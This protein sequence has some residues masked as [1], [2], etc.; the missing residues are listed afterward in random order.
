[1]KQRNRRL[2]AILCVLCMLFTSMPVSAWTDTVPATPTDLL[3]AV[4]EDSENGSEPEQ[5]DTE[6]TETDNREEQETEEPGTEEPKTEEPE[7]KEPETEEP[8]TEEAA[9]EEPGNKE[10]E[11]G[12][13]ETAEPKKEEPVTEEPETEEPATEEPETEEPTTDEPETEEPEI[14]KPAADT[15]ITGSDDITVTGSLEGNPPEDYLIRFIPEKT[16]KLCLILTT[17]VELSA[18]VTDEN[19]GIKKKFAFDHNDEDGMTVLTLPYYKVNRDSTY[20]IRISGRKPADFSIRM[21]KMS[22]LKAEEENDGTDS[23]I[24]AEDSAAS[25]PAETLTDTSSEPQTEIPDET[26]AEPAAENQAAEEGEA[27]AEPTTG[28]S[29]TE[30]TETLA[31]GAD[32]TPTEPAAEDS[33]TE[34]AETQAAGADDTSVT[35][36]AAEIP[37]EPAENPD[38]NRTEKRTESTAGERTETPE[39]DNTP[40]EANEPAQEQPPV[41]D[42]EPAEQDTQDIPLTPADPEPADEETPATRTDL[43]PADPETPANRTDPEPA[44]EETPA[45]QT[46]LGPADEGT[47]ATQTD[48]GPADGETAEVRIDATGSDTEAWITFM[49]DADIPQDAVLQVREIPEE[50]QKKYLARTVRTLKCDDESYLYYTKYLELK[51]LLDGEAVSLDTPVTVH[52]NLPDATEGTDA[53]QVVRFR[54]LTA[55]LLDSEITGRTISFRT[56]SLDVFGIGNALTPLTT[57]ETELA[58]VEVLGF[59][60]DTEI[61]LKQ[62]EAPKVEEGLDVLG[63]FTVEDQTK[64]A[65]GEEQ[66]GLWIRAELNEDAD[67]SPMESVALYRVEDGQAEVLMEDLSENNGITELDSQ[68]L[69]VIRDTGYRHLT[70]TVNPDESNEDRQVTLDGMMP[71]EAEANVVDVT[72]Q[73]TD[74]FA[75]DAAGNEPAQET[76][77][78][79]KDREQTDETGE[80]S[81]EESA[82]TR[83]TLAAFEISISHSEG[84]YQPDEGK[85]ISVEIVDSRISADRNIELWHIKDD[86]TR[87]QITDF[88]VEEGRIAF[89]A[90]GFSVYVVIDH[91]D[92]TVV[93]PRVEF[94][95]ISKTDADALSTGTT[96][97]YVTPR[98]TF[99]NMN[100]EYQCT[101]ILH[102]S[103]TLELITDP[104]N[105]SVA[106]MPDQFF[107]GWYVVD[108][109]EI[110]GSSDKYG[111]GISN[112]NLYYSWPVHPEAIS[113]GKPI[114]ITETNVQIG[115][116]IHWSMEGIS[117]SGEVDSDGTLH[118]LL[119]PVYK[120]YNFVNFML[121]AR[122]E[123]E[124]GQQTTPAAKNL[125]TRKLIAM[126]SAQSVEVKI[127]DVRSNSKDSTHLIF[128]GWEYKD[129]NG[130]W[131]QKQTVDYEGVEKTDPGR[132]GVYLTDLSIDDEASIDLYPIFVEARWVD[133]V[134][135]ISGV[136][137]SFVGSR[138]LEAWGR[139]LDENDQTIPRTDGENVFESLPVPERPGYTFAGWYAFAATDPET[140]D[141]T[142][143]PEHENLQPMT[144]NYVDTTSQDNYVTYPVHID[145]MS[146]VPITD[147]SG[148]I[149]FSGTFTLDT[150]NGQVKLFG[151]ENGKLKFYEAMDRLKL[152]ARWTPADTKITVIYWT[153]NAEND[154]YTA[155]A[156]RTIT[157]RQL[158]EGLEREDIVSGST[159]TLSDLVNCPD[160]D[161]TVGIA[162]NEILDDVGAV[163]KK[164]DPNALVARE[165]IF[166]ELNEDL[167]DESQVIDGQGET[168]FNVYFSRIEF[169]LVFHVGHDGYAKNR[170]QQSAPNDNWIEYM[171]RDAG[172]PI[173]GQSSA[174]VSYEGTTPDEF[175]M[176]NTLTDREYTSAYH[177]TLENIKKDYVP[178]KNPAP[179]DNDYNL[180]TITAKY[181]AYIGDQWPSHANSAW[182]FPVGISKNNPNGDG[183]NKTLYIWTA[184]YDS[185]YFAVAKARPSTVS[186]GSNADING[187]F[188]YMSGELCASQD[189]NSVINDAHVHHLVAYFG[190][191]AYDQRFK[192]YHT[193]F[194]AVPGGWLPD[195]VET[196]P[197]TDFVS[198]DEFSLTTWT[199]TYTNGDKAEIIG[200][201]FYEMDHD[202]LEEHLKKSPLQVIS[203]LPPQSQLA[204]EIT[205]YDTVYSCYEN[206]SRP[207]P[208][209]PGQNDYH[210]YFFYRP[211]E[212][213]LTLDFE[214]EPKTQQFYYKE[215]LSDALDYEGYE[216]PVKEGHVFLGWYPNEAGEGEPF[217]FANE[218][219]PAEGVVLYPVFRQLDYIVRIDPNGGEIDHWHE[220]STSGGASTGFRANYN[221]TISAY[222]FLER[223]YIRIDDAEAAELGADHT[224]Y[225]INTQYIS[226]EHDGRFVPSDLRNAMYLTA[227]EIDQYWTDYSN[228]PTEKFTSRGATKFTSKTAWMDAYFGG[229]DLSSLPKYRA[230]NTNEHY[231]FMGWYQVYENGS[232]ASAPFDFNTKVKED[233]RIRAMWRLDGGYYLKYNTVFA[234]ENEPDKV[235]SGTMYQWYDPE[236]PTKQLYAD[237]SHTHILRGP[238]D[239]TQGWV[240]RGWRIVRNDGTEEEPVWVPLE[241]D[242]NNEVVYYQPG[243]RF[244]VDAQYATE[245]PEGSSGA[246]IHMQAYYEPEQN[247]SRRPKVTELILDANEN[248]GGGYIRE[249]EGP[250][251]ALDHPGTSYIDTERNLDEQGRPTR[252]LFGDTENEMAI[253]SNTALHLYRYASTKKDG[254]QFFW[255]DTDLFTLLGFDP[256]ADHE[257]PSTGH[258]YVPAYSPDS[259][260]AVTRKDQTEPIVLYAMW[261]PK[262]YVTFRNNTDEDITVELGGAGTDTVRIVNQVAGEYD[263]IE[264]GR[265]LVVPAGEEI[266]IVLPKADP[267]VDTFTATVQNDHIWKKMSVSGEF[268][269]GTDYGT[270]ETDVPYGYPLTYTAVLQ[271][272][273][274]GIV[275]TYTEKDDL[276]VDYDINGGVWTET[277][278]AYEHVEGDLYLLDSENMAGRKYKPADPTRASLAF[279]GWTTNQDIKDHTDF[280]RTTATTW[281]ETVLL[282]QNGESLLEL[283]RREFLWD[284]GDPPPYHDTLYAVWSQI[285]TVTFDLLKEGT[286]YHTW[287]G[288]EPVVSDVPLAYTFW[289]HDGDDRYV[290][291]SV[292]AGDKASKPED[293]QANG[294]PSG[295]SWGFLKWLNRNNTTIPFAST[296]K[297]ASNNDII[298]NTYDFDTPVSGP[299]TLV[300]SWTEKLPQYYTFTVENH[301]ENGSAD[302]EFNYTIAVVDEQVWGKFASGGGNKVGVPDQRWGSVTTKLKN[303]ETY[304]VRITVTQMVSGW[305]AYGIGIDVFDSRGTL[306]KSGQV[307]YCDGNSKKNYTS[308]Y[309]YT[310]KITQDE[311]YDCSTTVAVDPASVVGSIVYS[312][313]GT[314]TN[315]F[316]FTSKHNTTTSQSAT[317]GGTPENDFVNG[318]SNSLRIV[319]TNVMRPIV[320]PT[321]YTSRRTP[322]ILL[323]LIGLILAL[324]GTGI[325]RKRSKED[326]TEGNPSCYAGTA[327]N[328]PP[329]ARKDRDAPGGKPGNRD[330]GPK[331]LKQIKVRVKERGSP[332][333]RGNPEKIPRKKKTELRNTDA[334]NHT[335]TM[336]GEMNPMKKTISI[337][338]TI[339]LL[340][341]ACAA[342][343]AGASGLSNGV[344][345]AYTEKDT[346]IEQEK[347]IKIKKEITAYNPDSS[348]KFVYGPAITYNYEIA[349]ASGDELVSITDDPDVHESGIAA[350]ATALP[351]VSGVT[352]TGTAENKIEW[353]NADILDVSAAGTANYKNLTVDFSNVVFTQPGVYRYKITETP[354]TY[355]TSGVTEGTDDAHYRYLDVYVMRSSTFDDGSTA[356][357]WTIY[358][359]VCIDSS[360]GEDDITPATTAKTNGFVNSSS[361]AGTSTADEYRT[362][363]LTIGKTLSG[364]AAMSSHK[365]PFDATWTAGTA[366][367]TF[368]F[369]V[370]TSGTAQ[371]TKTDVAA[372]AANAD[373]S[374]VN[375][376]AV[377][378]HMKVGGASAVGTADK[379][380]SP[381]IANGATVKYIG[382]PAGTKVTV[383]ET[384]D[385]TG[386]TYTTTATEKIGTG[387]AADVAFTGGTA[388]M[389]TD[390]KTATTAEN[391][392]VIYAQESAPAAGSD[393]EIQYTNTLALISPTGYVARFAPYALMLIG[394]I[395]LLIIAKKHKKHPDE[396]DN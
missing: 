57:Q 342:T 313:V 80:T 93:N 359:Y 18:S 179:T 377:A 94:H 3:P 380:G 133:F 176:I 244:V 132:D 50:E 47:P 125:M 157:T 237:Q 111:I 228:Y 235:I 197:G 103:E 256:S 214:D 332:G 115:D 92:N 304:S 19:T 63:S 358:G 325:F 267:G 85:P 61:T 2:I 317:F 97:Y 38:E 128:T 30:T 282:P 254:K 11:A 159:I 136:G 140:G 231:S 234:P 352:L 309:I 24:Q 149:A 172:M 385:V 17:D 287:T 106:G 308:D 319:F 333:L 31:A 220:S 280:S 104:G 196:F 310:L 303:N 337:L 215:T 375:G 354:A 353:T 160:A 371:V 202:L 384:N 318:Q 68:Q 67:L 65:A 312:P 124:E 79:Q 195:G 171:Y 261:E 46:D 116:T 273:K 249:E 266:K 226:W 279:I 138:F 349:A 98:Y 205:G 102:N 210:V 59:S 281:N 253:Q 268:P 372:A 288:P 147:G 199:T 289:K 276:Q 37:V 396:E 164:E 388:S 291:Y 188:R 260:I 245:I 36:Q 153:E 156:A 298:N 221:E 25:E 110:S 42:G 360:A 22:I 316:S 207:N 15:E 165:E 189:G 344:A 252:I 236:D 322:Y 330:T 100:N 294:V 174:G 81:E 72:E 343:T 163:P 101:Q 212:Y 373:G 175:K 86:G 339:T 275:V 20:L 127:S 284:F 203:N 29:I 120:K 52:V 9:T 105:V 367:G 148:Q 250:L 191:A 192:Q 314:G 45:T 361:T 66:N 151:N 53:L 118:V 326:D 336:K 168:I 144:I 370:E 246:I 264:A 323:M 35:E 381:L 230:M 222:S 382:I 88:T 379:D 190:R 78:E 368:Q 213:T 74:C 49:S 152:Y 217:D 90:A 355:G 150:G 391:K 70:L 122:E 117:G 186:G 182:E 258:K 114:T 167:S 43:E 356:A 200:H 51:L 96:A 39:A 350:E 83:T 255:N 119:A 365:F 335:G 357:E 89:E 134:S 315:E 4:S 12:E 60:A 141:I 251:P 143:L 99:R 338:L 54:T 146:A 154:E 173:Q 348:V 62:A 262:I 259:V 390:K 346:P 378:A 299:V 130:T 16:Q 218:R 387:E 290:Y 241:R 13:P 227:A 142:N 393:V 302:E 71:K 73:Y 219:M 21:A 211:K 121:Y 297:D 216:E 277:S 366:S 285:E 33:A 161:F 247:T 56:D 95:F 270:G 209:I 340:L 321:G 286:T 126:G 6:G 206:H 329:G 394:G 27:P 248:Y 296:A 5:A 193:L 374:S 123:N 23:G 32:E 7:T 137:A 201:S 306:V 362:Y 208:E 166:F 131:I 363:N 300:T 345:G 40:E 243:E 242:A 177:A 109:V 44:D 169:T 223:N 187:I 108:P 383:T 328:G 389:S 327:G 240:F 395:A 283:V 170:G 184:Y 225:Y 113:F 162:S 84:E 87:E 204:T 180:Y 107:Y 178:K 292:I 301:V 293:P 185:L 155:S 295:K 82:G 364:D 232:V 28:N 224:Y 183:T 265:D 351:G 135:G 34:T 158:C 233:V 269:E 376:T 76:A 257:N 263:R 341:A 41:P 69:A 311:K 331:I 229:H 10:A 75:A 272:D 334:F 392:T 1:M 239:V 386:T 55:R 181:G 91:E 324:A 129:D 320:A 271:Q 8:K 369:I 64:A 145:G 58:S 48:L 139:A 194:E 112:T 26:P 198:D 278:T 77:A 305:T 14:E 238:I 347:T 307:V 274:E